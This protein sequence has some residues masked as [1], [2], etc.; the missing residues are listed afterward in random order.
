MN[1]I[2]LYPLTAKLFGFERHIA[3]GMWSLAR[4]AAMLQPRLRRDPQELSAQFRQPLFL[5]A[6]AALK[7]VRAGDG[8]EFTLLGRDSGKVHVN[9]A[10]R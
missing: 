8:V 1:P 7:H 10:L 2:H 9:G 6:R 5:P 3:H 4:C